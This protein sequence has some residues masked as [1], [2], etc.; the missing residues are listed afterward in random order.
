MQADDDEPKPQ[1]QDD[2]DDPEKELEALRL[3]QSKAN[4]RKPVDRNTAFLEF[5]GND[6]K[7]FEDKIISNRQDLKEH[8]LK[9]KHF[10]EICNLSK[11]ELDKIK[12]KLDAKA[13]EKRLT[14]ND[15]MMGFDDED[16]GGQVNNGRQEIID[17]EEL[18]LI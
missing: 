4:K 10:T 16:N 2:E 12:A 14:Q 17:E 1:S 9:V 6:G 3:R 15:E 13:E 7:Q 5:K 8:K 18:A 11:H